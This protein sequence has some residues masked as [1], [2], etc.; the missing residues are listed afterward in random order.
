MLVIVSWVSFWLDPNAIPARVSLGVTTLLTMATQISGINASLPPVSYTKAIDVWTGSCLTFVFGA[1]LEF[2]L[3]NYASRSDAHR[4]QAERLFQAQQQA[5][6]QAAMQQRNQGQFHPPAQQ[7]TNELRHSATTNSLHR[8]HRH[9]Q[10]AGSTQQRQASLKSTTSAGNVRTSTSAHSWDNGLDV[11]LN[12]VEAQFISQQQQQQRKSSGGTTTTGILGRLGLRSPVD[13]TE[14]ETSTTAAANA[15]AASFS[16]PSS[17]ASDGL[18]PSIFGPSFIPSS[19]A[20]ASRKRKGNIWTRWLSRFPNRSKRIDVISRI[21]F[22]LMFAFFNV[23][24][25]V[26]YLWR[27]DLMEL[28]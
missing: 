16:I 8:H 23:V 3:V 4:A 19:S 12:D 21:F 26:T 14:Q 28:E 13:D 7:L 17:M 6:L 2:A 24:Y 22:P 11:L 10:S 9:R 15:L 25:W 18:M 20:G 1:L 27:D 5:L